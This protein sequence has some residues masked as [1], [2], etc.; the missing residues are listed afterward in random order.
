MHQHY[1]NRGLGF[2]LPA[3]ALFA[4]AAAI[5]LAA[6]CG[7]DPTP[8]PTTAPP[9][10]TPTASS[11][12]AQPPRPLTLPDDEAP[13]S[14]PVEWWYYSGTMA[15]EDGNDYG[16]HFVIFQVQD[17]RGGSAFYMSH[18]SVLDVGEERH[19]QAAVFGLGPQPRPLTG[20]DL[21]VDTWT[22]SGDNGAHAFAM[23]AGTFGFDLAVSA[24][25]PA[26]LHYQGIG[27]LQALDGWT[28]YYS[29]TDMELS[30]T[31]TLDGLERDVTGTAWM[32][33][34]WGDFQVLGYPYGWEWFA[35]SMDN[36]H[37]LMITLTRETN[38]ES[39]V[40]GTLR[41][42]SGL[43]THIAGDDI[44]IETLRTWRSPHTD[45]EYPAGWRIDIPVHGIA[46]T[47]TPLKDD[48]E[49]TAVI[50]PVPIYWEGLAAADITFEGEPVD[51]SAYVELVGFAQH[52]PTPTPT[53]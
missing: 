46:M 38:G 24:T 34:Q 26:A 8:T 39:I 35:V 13:H 27:Y 22:L 49:F 1:L 15:D 25:G 32:D 11:L 9:P 28:Y 17:P 45:G 12:A 48:Q 3:M 40:Y 47:L 41:G 14:D 42:P 53:P 37:E 51:G 4:V 31:L 19:E 5:L 7:G 20:F 44:V 33:H 29:W 50:P 36:D 30:G 16:F 52:T 23:S 18:A 2:R 10:P 6:A 21:N 43:T